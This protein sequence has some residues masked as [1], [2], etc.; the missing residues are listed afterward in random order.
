MQS[1]DETVSSSANGALIS[2]SSSSRSSSE[3]QVLQ[4]ADTA[5]ERST[6]LVRDS[7]S[8]RRPT[9][10]T[11]PAIGVD[12]EG[13]RAGTGRI[14]RTDRAPASLDVGA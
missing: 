5:G 12:G 3:R 9:D 11:A 8:R 2:S 14:H 4:Q 7:D 6:T 10:A 13:R 1:A